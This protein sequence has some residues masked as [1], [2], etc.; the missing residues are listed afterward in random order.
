M[1][2]CIEAKRLHHLV[3]ASAKKNTRLPFMAFLLFMVS[4]HRFG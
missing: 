2:M 4:L 3:S 1:W